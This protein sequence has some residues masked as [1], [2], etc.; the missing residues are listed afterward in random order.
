MRV[1]LTCVSIWI[2]LGAG[3]ALAQKGATGPVADLNARAKELHE[4]DPAGSLTVAQQA[5]A[6]SR[7][8]KD[9]LGE[10]EALNYVAY[11]YRQQSLLDL[12][13]KH[14]LDS[15]RLFVQAGDT[16]GESQGYNTL[17]L[18]EADAGRFPEALEYHLKAQ[19][20]RQRTGDKEG[21]AYS[22]NNLGNAYRN[23]AQYDQ[24]LEY[25]Q[26]GLALKIEL[27]NR[28][29][30]AF[31]HH[32]IGL[33]YFAMQDY[34]KA[35]EAYRRGLAIREELKDTRAIAVSL[36]GIGSVE[37]L[38]NPAAALLTYERALALRR[39]T[40]DQRGEMATEINMAGV[41]R[42][43]GDLTRA[44]EAFDRALALG[45]Q[46]DAPLMRS[47]AL[48]GLA[49]VEAARGDY[50]AA[51][52][53]QLQHQA[54]RDEM[55]SLENAA[56]LQRLQ[57]AHEAERQAAEIASLQEQRTA[58]GV[59]AVLVALSLA[60]LYARFR[61][62]QQSEA[63]FRAQAEQ[64]QAAMDRVQTLKGLLPICASCKKI[65]DDNGYWTQVERYVAEHSAAEFTHSICPSCF[66]GLYPEHTHSPDA[67]PAH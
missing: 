50:R 30:E 60:L 62:K 14:A 37:A 29:S 38:T 58:L 15:V 51:Y 17:G 66:E 32:N 53:H 52:E 39:E 23:M 18:I 31:S 48:K 46:I 64:L 20:I 6:L 33:V 59:I 13:R 57:V 7:E 10:A 21:L 49:E 4:T 19:A 41:F 43:M 3:E 67:P 2:F 63:R 34:L 55:F 56:R 1:L 35:L 24:A 25:H 16:Y 42:S 47:N 22:F 54:A 65:R 44:T 11:A 12:A 27:G 36:N 40:G 8:S 61:L 28:S 5:L 9:V 45:G 26:Q